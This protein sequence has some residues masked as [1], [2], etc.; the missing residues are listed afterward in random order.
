MRTEATSFIRQRPYQVYTA[1]SLK[2]QPG[3]S[4]NRHVPRHALAGNGK[5][6]K[7]A[8][9]ANGASGKASSEINQARI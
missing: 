6:P 7:I 3:A 5:P 8:G 9:P 1:F 4:S 2:A